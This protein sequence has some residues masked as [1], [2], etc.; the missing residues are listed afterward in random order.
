MTS[1]HLRMFYFDFALVLFKGNFGIAEFS[2]LMLSF[3]S[4]NGI[5]S[6]VF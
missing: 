2:V 5:R 3:V 4:A 6:L 1:G